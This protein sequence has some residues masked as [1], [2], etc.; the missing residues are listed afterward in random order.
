MDVDDTADLRESAGFLA[1]RGANVAIADVA[2]RL[3]VQLATEDEETLTSVSAPAANGDTQNAARIVTENSALDREARRLSRMVSDAL[4]TANGFD[5][6]EPRD[7]KGEW[8]PGQPF[9]KLG[10][11]AKGS[12]DQFH[13]LLQQRG[14]QMGG[15]KFVR[16]EESGKLQTFYH[17][18]HP[19]GFMHFHKAQDL[20]K[21]LRTDSA[22]LPKPENE[23]AVPSRDAKS[24]QASSIEQVVKA[25][26]NKGG[27][28]QT[29]MDY[30]EV[31]GDEAAHIK[32]FIPNEDF[33]GYKHLVDSEVAKKILRDHGAD[34]RPITAQDFA[35]LP[36]YLKN[37]ES[38]H[39]VKVIGKLDRIV[40]V[41]RDESGRLMLIEEIRTGRQK[42]ALKSM[43]RP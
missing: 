5:P 17:V 13:A 16:D 32:K 36:T 37:A 41:S 18:T 33:T 22:T 11:N 24:K 19:D 3:G 21:F 42:L 23:G 43:Y 7:E 34:A 30:A 40:H 35:K 29:W 12:I 9:H 31:D 1:D 38:H 2:D 15:S 28:G 10:P 20:E 6:N 25:A 4:R 27:D 26:S 39:L 14:Y 8:S